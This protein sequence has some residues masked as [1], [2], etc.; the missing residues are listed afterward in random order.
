M[1][2][3]TRRTAISVT[4][5]VAAPLLTRHIVVGEMLHG[6]VER[7]E[8]LIRCHYKR[9]LT[10]GFEAVSNQTDTTKDEEDQSGG[11][12][13]KPQ[14]RSGGQGRLRGKG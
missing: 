7:N 9:G 12:G 10:A 5:A 6:G 3:G 14:R 4:A 8:S 13:P 1:M 2:N 11:G